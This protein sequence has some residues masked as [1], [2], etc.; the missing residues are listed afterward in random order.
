MEVNF[1]LGPP[2]SVTVIE[3]FIKGQIEVIEFKIDGQPAH[4]REVR[5]S[6]R[7]AWKGGV[8]GD[9]LF[10]WETVIAKVHG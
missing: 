4:E 5:G 1:R 2:K 8:V 9:D 10:D 3:V 6:G 7:H